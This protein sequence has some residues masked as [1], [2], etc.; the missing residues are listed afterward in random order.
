MW[1]ELLL[2]GRLALHDNEWYTFMDLLNANLYVT[3]DKISYLRWNLRQEMEL[4]VLERSYG[5][6]SGYH[7]S[8]ISL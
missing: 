6:P 7:Y 2:H 8:S 5:S 4:V 3:R 1:N